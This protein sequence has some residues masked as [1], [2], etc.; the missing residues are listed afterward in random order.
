MAQLNMDLV[1]NDKF[2]EVMKKAA[3]QTQRMEKHLEK[4][5]GFSSNIMTS[6][7][8]GLGFY[9]IV[10]YAKEALDQYTKVN[11]ENVKIKDLLQNQKNYSEEKLK[12]L[13]EQRVQYEQIGISAEKIA[14][15]QRA[16]YERYG[17]SN[18]TFEASVLKAAVNYGTV[19]G[20]DPQ[21]AVGAIQQA[22]GRYG[23]TGRLRAGAV[24]FN[25]SEIE[26]L[27]K[28]AKAVTSINERTIILMTAINKKYEGLAEDVRKE[29]PLYPLQKAMALLTPEVGKLVGVL[30]NYVA[31]K[32]AAFADKL[33]DLITNHLENFK[34]KVKAV[35]DIFKGI[36]EFFVVRKMALLFTAGISEL[37]TGFKVLK[38][39]VYELSSSIQMNKIAAEGNR[40]PEGTAAHEWWNNKYGNAASTGSVFSSMLGRGSGIMMMAGAGLGMVSDRMQPGG[41]QTATDYASGMLSGAGSGAMLG[42]VF[43]GLGSAI[44]AAIGGVIGAGLVYWRRTADATDKLAY[45]TDKS[46]QEKKLDEFST[47]V[48]K[49][50]ADKN[51][52]ENDLIQNNLKQFLAP[53]IGSIPIDYANKSKIGLAGLNSLGLNKDQELELAK[54]IEEQK[55]ILAAMNNKDPK[56]RLGFTE[57]RNKYISEFGGGSDTGQSNSGQSGK[58]SVSNVTGI[59]PKIIN[60]NIHDGLIN[61]QNINA[62]NVTESAAQIEKIV[63]AAILN[64]INAAELLQN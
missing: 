57:A 43:P 3:E 37:V 51:K 30:A 33:R 31:P 27:N 50:G 18:S 35:A 16:I 62:A 60:I 7:G 34:E 4:I 52:L 25:S 32:I 20:T 13:K 39:S 26:E 38:N 2:S 12:I 21:A 46:D 19:E 63:T 9:K 47:L 6:I 22:A 1:L 29:N 49:K 40:F 59:Q 11:Q 48:F 17:K 28:K 58:G 36:I 44:G 56:L 10:E 61:H 41:A 42:S 24:G 5:Q 15:A 54:N 45:G 23:L 14:S 55:F 8:V 64:G 53:S